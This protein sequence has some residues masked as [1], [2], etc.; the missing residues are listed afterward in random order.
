MV[1]GGQEEVVASPPMMF[2]DDGCSIGQIYTTK[3]AIIP[4]INTEIYITRMQR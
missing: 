1:V 4:T 3:L 2:W